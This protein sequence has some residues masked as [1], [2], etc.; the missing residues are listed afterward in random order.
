MRFS[1]V[2]GTAAVGLCL[3][4]AAAPAAAIAQLPQPQTLNAAVA[5]AVQYNP[6]VLSARLRVERLSGEAVH[7]GVPA[8]SNPRLELQTGQRSTAGATT[9]DFFISRTSHH[10]D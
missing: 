8:P 9:T 7:A 4:V 6:A 5:W 1:Y 2:F 10:G 3:A